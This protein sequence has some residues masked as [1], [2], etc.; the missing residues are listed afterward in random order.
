MTR[1]ATPQNEALLLAQARTSTGAQLEKICRRYRG[2][3]AD[4]ADDETQR[5]V[6]RKHMGDGTVRIGCPLRGHPAPQAPS[7]R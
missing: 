7:A 1:V 2:V 4:P 5:H 3:T 6:T